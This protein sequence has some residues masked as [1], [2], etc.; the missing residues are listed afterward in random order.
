[1]VTP[2]FTDIEKPEIALES[3]VPNDVNTVNVQTLSSGGK[4]LAT[5]YYI[6]WAGPDYDQTAWADGDG[7]IIE[8]V[9]FG[10]GQGLWIQGQDGD[11]IRFPA[12]EL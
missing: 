1:M 4:A 2:Q 12:P 3:L 7:N 9:T 6:D 11:T 10:P 8:N 5:Y